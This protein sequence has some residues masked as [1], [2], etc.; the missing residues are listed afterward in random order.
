ML[1]L[2]NYNKINKGLLTYTSSTLLMP[3]L[4]SQPHYNQLL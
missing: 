3:A 2:K 1:K 4:Q